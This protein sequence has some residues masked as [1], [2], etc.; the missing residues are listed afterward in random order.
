M[1]RSKYTYILKI[2]FFQQPYKAFVYPRMNVINLKL[3]NQSIKP[4]RTN[5][6]F[7]KILIY[8]GK[9][10]NFNNPKKNISFKIYSEFIW[11]N[12][13]MNYKYTCPNIVKNC[14]KLNQIMTITQ[15]LVKKHLIQHQ[16]KRK[17]IL[18]KQLTK[19]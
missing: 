4:L 16:Q 13:F 2:F 11:D 8:F 10:L 3:R 5:L 6:K 19:T 18:N 1:T 17:K 12:G 7:V 14:F 15:D 9:I